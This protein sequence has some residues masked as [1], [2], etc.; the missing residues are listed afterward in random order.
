MAVVSLSSY[1]G[2][3]GTL[4][5]TNV[6]ADCID[7]ASPWHEWAIEQLQLCSE[8]SPLHVDIVVFTEL[9]VPGPSV[10]D[11]DAMLDVYGTSRTPL[12]WACASL[13]AA[14]FALYRRR[15]GARHR[16]AATSGAGRGQRDGPAGA[17]AAGIAR[18]ASKTFG[19]SYPARQGIR[20]SSGLRVPPAAT[21]RTCV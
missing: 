7:K 19:A 16:P 12:P 17:H 13:A 9:L 8:R 21:F 3:A 6:W 1:D 11:L 5:D 2:S 15:G 10:R 14:V 20:L 4:V 18:I